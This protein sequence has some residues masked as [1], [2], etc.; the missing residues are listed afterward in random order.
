MV[1]A[2]ELSGARYD[3]REGKEGCRHSVAGLTPGGEQ[4]VRRAAILCRWD[5]RRGMGGRQDSI[6]KMLTGVDGKQ[7][8]AHLCTMCQKVL[9]VKR[10]PMLGVKR[11]AP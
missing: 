8:V 9:S 3:D 5:T 4:T 6:V 7:L 1:W 2:L 10:E 11:F